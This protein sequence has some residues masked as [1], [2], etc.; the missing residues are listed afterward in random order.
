MTTPICKCGCDRPIIQGQW[1]AE[2]DEAFAERLA[3]GYARRKCARLHKPLPSPKGRTLQ[4]PVSWNRERP[5]MTEQ[6]K[7]RRVEDAKYL[8]WVRSLPCLVTGCQYDAETHHQS[9]RGKGGTG[10]RADDYRALP[11]CCFHHTLGG[12][13]QAQGSYHGMGKLTGWKFWKHYGIDVESTIH[14]LNCLWLEQG[15]KFKEG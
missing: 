7:D 2:G 14:R 6:P 5:D 3:T 11:L 10:T 4:A 15:K 13:S 9:E 1:G 8:E 12:T